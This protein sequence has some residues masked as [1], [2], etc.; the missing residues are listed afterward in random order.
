MKSSESGPASYRSELETLKKEH[1]LRT[2]QPVQAEESKRHLTSEGRHYLNFC[3]N[4][5]LGLSTHPELI[6]RSCEAAGRYGTSSSSSRLVSGSLDIHHQ[7]EERIAALYGVEGCLL[8]GTGYQANI[9]I[10]PALTDRQDLILADRLVHHSLIQG[11]LLSRADFRRFRHNDCDHLED[12]LRGFRESSPRAECWVVTESLFS[13]DGD[14]APLD[15]MIQLCRRYGARLM[16]DDAHAF[17]VWGRSGLGYGAGKEGIDLLIGT[18]GKAGG[19]YGAFVLGSALYRDYLINRCGGL[20][21]TTAP[22]PPQIAA[23]EAAFELIP[24]LDDRRDHL[25]LQITRLFEG[26]NQLG[27][28]T[29]AGRSQII[30]ILLDNEKEALELAG[31]LRERGIFVQ[32]IRPPT[33]RRS[34]IRLT[35][36]SEHTET[37]LETL[38]EALNV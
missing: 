34:R 9:S 13:M 1:R 12:L 26:L 36:T 30:P 5:Y 10:L 22:P 17:G 16:V 28:E 3:S 4:D 18:L 32:A 7:L 35:L 23:A 31:R 15:D 6:R 38:L 14:V 11:A 19:G 29:G 37:D 25:K 21:Y 20:I 27:L 8:F 33:V 2:L 24:Q